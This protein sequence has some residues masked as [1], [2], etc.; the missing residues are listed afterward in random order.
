MSTEMQ[1]FI[2]INAI[3]ILATIREAYDDIVLIT[4]FQ[5]RV[6]FSESFMKTFF[7]VFNAK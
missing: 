4:N 6:T 5:S 1:M 2:E 3:A 7:H